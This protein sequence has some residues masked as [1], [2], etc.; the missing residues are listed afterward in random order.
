MA[1]SNGPAPPT[2][3]FRYY[4]TRHTIHGL[5]CLAVGVALYYAGLGVEAAALIGAGVTFLGFG[6]GAIP[7]P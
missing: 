6:S 2:G 7:V 3:G 4:V 5:I 1:V